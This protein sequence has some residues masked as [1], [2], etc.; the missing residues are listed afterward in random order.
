MALSLPRFLIFASFALLAFTAGG[1]VLWSGVPVPHVDPTNPAAWEHATYTEVN[2][3]SSARFTFVSATQ[4]E[5]TSGD[6]LESPADRQD[7]RMALAKILNLDYPRKTRALSSRHQML[8]L[9]A[10]QGWEVYHI[11]AGGG[12]YELRRRVA[13]GS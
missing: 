6:N 4:Y 12:T 1:S 5:Q 13:A 11:S 10:R 7:L 3:G 8:D 9:F 2:R